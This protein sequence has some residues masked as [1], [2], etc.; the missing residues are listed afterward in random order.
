VAAI[1]MSTLSINVPKKP[2]LLWLKLILSSSVTKE[3]PQKT[4]GNWHG[5]AIALRA[6]RTGSGRDGLLYSVHAFAG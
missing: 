3:F 5:T 1:R 6:L 2:A 4:L